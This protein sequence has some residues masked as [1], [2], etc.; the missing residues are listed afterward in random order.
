MATDIHYK[1]PHVDEWDLTIERDLG[2]GFGVRVGYDGSHA[3]NLPTDINLNQIAPNTQGY[4]A[5][6]ST[7]PF[8]QL[9]AISYQD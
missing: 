2:Q 3:T 6:A 4:N 8:P 5:L 7:A 1:D 9:Y